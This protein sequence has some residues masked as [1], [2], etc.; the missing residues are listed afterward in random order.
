M[1]SSEHRIQESEDLMFTPFERNI[2]VWRQLWRVLERSHLIVQIIDARN[3][4]RFR[5]EDLED[6]VYDVEGPEGEK[7]TGKGFRKALLLINKADL[8]SLE[9]RYVVFFPFTLNLTQ[10]IRVDASGPTSLRSATL[11][12]LS[13]RLSTLKNYKRRGPRRKKLRGELL[14]AVMTATKKM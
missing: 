8:L 10:I 2:E 9:Q 12:M 1:L 13:S 3:P 4:L 6:Y 11:N 5:C 14:S 7:G